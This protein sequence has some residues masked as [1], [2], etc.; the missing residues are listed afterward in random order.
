MQPDK[1]HAY[2]ALDRDPS[3]DFEKLRLYTT[4]VGVRALDW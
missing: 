2:A 4:I 1:C 3:C